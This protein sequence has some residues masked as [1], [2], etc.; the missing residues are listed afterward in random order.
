MLLVGCAAGWLLVLV[1]VVLLVAFVLLLGCPASRCVVGCCGAA[2]VLQ[3][4]RAR[5]KGNTEVVD[6]VERRMLL[7]EGNKG[8]VV[9]SHTM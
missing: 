4:V 2:V 3:V 6:C 9:R 8:S 7:V 5:A 1:V